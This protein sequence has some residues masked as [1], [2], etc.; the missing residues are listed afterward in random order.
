MRP[1]SRNNARYELCLWRVVTGCGC[2]CGSRSWRTCGRSRRWRRRR[3][4]P[5]TC[6]LTT[7]SGNYSH[8]SRASSPLRTR[9]PLHPAK[10]V[11]HIATRFRPRQQEYDCK[12]SCNQNFPNNQLRYSQFSSSRSVRLS[13]IPGVEN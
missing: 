3:R 10:T 8:A 6:P 2:R 5:S 12:N 1:P 9:S 7:P 11:C 13:D 4:R